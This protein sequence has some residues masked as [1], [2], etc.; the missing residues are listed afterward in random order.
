[1]MVLV[2]GTSLFFDPLPGQTCLF[3]CKRCINLNPKL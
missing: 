2:K 1:M 3:T